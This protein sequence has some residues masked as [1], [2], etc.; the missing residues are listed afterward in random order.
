MMPVRKQILETLLQAWLDNQPRRHMRHIA[1]LIDHDNR[2][3]DIGH[4]LEML[5]RHGLVAHDNLAHYEITAAG[6]H[7]LARCA[8]A[9]ENNTRYRHG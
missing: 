4:H 9:R 2:L 1:Q 5:D 8:R 7:A 6:I 3:V